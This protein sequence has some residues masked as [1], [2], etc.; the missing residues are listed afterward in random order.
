MQTTSPL[1]A[2]S[3]EAKEPLDGSERREWKS[4]VKTQHSEN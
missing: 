1:M 4:W 2:E 3:E